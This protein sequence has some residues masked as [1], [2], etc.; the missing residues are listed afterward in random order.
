MLRPP[1]STTEDPSIPGDVPETIYVERFVV[2]GSTV[3]N[4]AE[5]AEVTAPFEERDLSFAELLQARSAVTQLY[6]DEGYIT[7]GAFI[8]PQTLEEGVV[9]I[10]VLEGTLEDINVDVVNEEDGEE[11]EVDTD[12]VVVEGYEKKSLKKSLGNMFGRKKK[13]KG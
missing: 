3:F 5:L 13:G 11:Q 8:P 7:S 4:E 1:G 2:N 6:V 12:F 10:Q 9:T